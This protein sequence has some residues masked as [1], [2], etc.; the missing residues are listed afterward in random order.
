MNNLLFISQGFVQILVALGAI[1]SGA[2]LILFPSGRL[3]QVPPGMLG[4]SPFADFLI[5]G[6]ILFL[7]NGVGQLAAGILTFRKNRLSGYLGAIFGIG[8]M[9][10]IFVQVNMIGGRNVLQYS[11]FAVGAL[12]TAFAFLIHAHLPAASPETTAGK[13]SQRAH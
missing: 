10:W 5:P 4:D 2:I 1:V 13:R 3:L 8:L 12:E 11:Y 7:V 9:I 6:I